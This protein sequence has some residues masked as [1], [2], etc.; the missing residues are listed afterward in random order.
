MICSVLLPTAKPL[1]ASDS[2]CMCLGTS[3][4]VRPHVNFATQLLCRL[5][6]PYK[7]H[8]LRPLLSPSMGGSPLCVFRFTTTLGLRHLV[9][10][11]R[12][13]G[14]F[15]RG[16]PDTLRERTLRWGGVLWP[17]PR[18]IRC[19]FASPSCQRSSS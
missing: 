10:L 5:D 19:V 3:V 11:D 8:L 16:S 14:A 4:T 2:S 1:L 17:T 15:G 6:F 12:R 7:R 13:G 18:A 9:I